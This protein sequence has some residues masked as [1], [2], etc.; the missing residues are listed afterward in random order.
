MLEELGSIYE[1]VGVNFK[2]NH[3][4]DVIVRIVTPF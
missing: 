3:L 4:H 1:S 2:I